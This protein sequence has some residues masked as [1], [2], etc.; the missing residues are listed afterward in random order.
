MKVTEKTKISELIKHSPE[1]IEV[2][3]SVNSH[4]NKL[5]NPILRKLLAS[6]VTLKEAAK[7]GKCELSVLIEK[8]KPLGFE[9]EIDMYEDSS[10]EKINEVI[11]NQIFDSL[12]VRP[13]LNQG[14]DPFQM[15]MSKVNILPLGKTLE[16]ISPFQP[17]PLI[18][19]L[20]QKNHTCICNEKE[21]IFSLFITKNSNEGLE[22]NVLEKKIINKIDSFDEFQN[23]ISTFE[24]ENKLERL[25]V[26]GLEMP[27]P[28]VT[29][30]EKLEYMP[31]EFALFVH[32]FQIPQFLLPEL[33]KRNFFMDYFIV[34][35]KEIHLLIYN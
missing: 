27:L 10:N 18:R 12:D 2:I 29:I 11:P 22:N 35:E 1:T 14:Q 33:E 26:R 7:I 31:K 17:I 32:H 28:M 19:I 20:E 30:L 9:F 13:I 24:K 21:G 3:A 8:L 15:I 5:R 6:R 34:E 25:D 23:K 16:I 4:F